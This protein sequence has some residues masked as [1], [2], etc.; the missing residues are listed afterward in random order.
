ME[1]GQQTRTQP[2]QKSVATM[3]QER[4]HYPH[5]PEERGYEAFCFSI[6]LCLLEKV[7]V[8]NLYNIILLYYYIA[9][10]AEKSSP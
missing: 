9:F 7:N 4:V 6:C 8:Q 3:I 10:K 2:Q 5:D 1:A